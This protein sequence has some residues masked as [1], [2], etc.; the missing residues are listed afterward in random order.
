MAN[1]PCST[2]AEF[3]ANYLAEESNRLADIRASWIL[4]AGFGVTTK[5]FQAAEAG[6]K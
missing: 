6:Q 1:R 3:L 2:N 5:A 4:Q